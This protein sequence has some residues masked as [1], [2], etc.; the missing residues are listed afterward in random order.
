MCSSKIIKIT[1]D[2]Y[3]CL[4][5]YLALD[6]YLS[7]LVRGVHLMSLCVDQTYLYRQVHN[8]LLAQDLST[9][10]EPQTMCAFLCNSRCLYMC[11]KSQ[12]G[13]RLCVVAHVQIR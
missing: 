8:L 12:N 11:Y 5:L 4:A 13:D 10:Q 6:F 3:V 1:R 2:K 7:S 9:D